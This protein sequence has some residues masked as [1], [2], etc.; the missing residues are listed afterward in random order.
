MNSDI[1]D[2][3]FNEL[4]CELACHVAKLYQK[5]SPVLSVPVIGEPI[6]NLLWNL[7]DF[8]SPFPTIEGCINPIMMEVIRERMGVPSEEFY[9]NLEEIRKNSEREELGLP[10]V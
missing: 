3:W 10:P 7:S 9:Q 6:M 4:R 8:I 1:K 2:N 5:S